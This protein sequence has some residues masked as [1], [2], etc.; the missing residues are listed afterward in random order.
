MKDI[1]KIENQPA[2]LDVNFEAVKKH[3]ATELARYDVVVTQDTLKDAKALATE[4][5]Q[6]RQQFEKR[7]KEEVA[8]ASE[9]VKAFDEKMKEL[10]KMCQDGR[11]KI[12]SQV[13]KFENETRAIIQKLLEELRAQLREEINILPEFHKAEFDDLVILSS[14]TGSGKLTKKAIDTLTGRVNEEKSLQDQTRLR[15][16]ELENQSYKAGLSAPL[17]RDHVA[18]FLFTTDE[19]YQAE[20]ERIIGA[21][22]K[23]Q[24][25]A[26]IAARQRI[27]REQEVEAQVQASQ[28]AKQPE[29][30]QEA[31][32]EP[33]AAPK[34]E[35]VVESKPAAQ[36][37]EWVAVVAEFSIEVPS[38]FSDERIKSKLLEQM[39]AAGFK[40]VPEVKVHRANPQQKA[41]GF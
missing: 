9:P 14:L 2:C 33:I 22:L 32:P 23:R 18:H 13:E 28:P 24:E 12:L 27:L 26:E 19:A 10:A 25:Q 5:N 11:T 3:L 34:S 6:T 16:V 31:K 38:S 1:I 39:K 37:T 21:E 30:V 20:L 36:G 35:P 29:P 40:S 15:L 7:R 8:K 4:L 17:T 41:G